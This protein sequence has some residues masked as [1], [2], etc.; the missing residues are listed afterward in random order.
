M[1][2]ETAGVQKESQRKNKIIE[3][4]LKLFSDKGY[5][6]TRVDEIAEQAGV[7]KA[8]IYYYFDK[9]E[10]IL[11]YLLDEF[12]AGLVTLSEDFIRDGIVKPIEGGQLV[13]RADYSFQFK[14]KEAL[15]VFEKK[16]R[17]MI[18]A[19]LHYILD[20]KNTVRVML[21]E[22]LK[23]YEK[24]QMS[25]F[26]LIDFRLVDMGYLDLMEQKEDNPIYRVVSAPDNDLRLHEYYSNEKIIYKFFFAVLPLLN[27]A[28]YF[29]DYRK[30]SGLSENELRLHLIDIYFKTTRYYLTDMKELT[31]SF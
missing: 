1:L 3:T 8:L 9:K 12:Y 16:T 7:N 11:N 2:K 15:A 22:S 25:L 19:M 17:Q 27:M 20:N 30:V 13:M 21:A 26:R 10:S 31:I 24:A 6:N 14:S 23:H 28:A 29:D 4:A 18:E 5:E